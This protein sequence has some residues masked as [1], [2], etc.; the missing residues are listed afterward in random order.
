M[1]SAQGVYFCCTLGLGLVYLSGFEFG[2]VL[3]G[4]YIYVWLKL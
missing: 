3:T 2:E 1:N 4:L